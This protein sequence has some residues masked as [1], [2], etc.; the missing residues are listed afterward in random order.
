MPSAGG[1]PGC[2]TTEERTRIL[3][4][5]E[6][7]VLP[8]FCAMVLI[9]EPDVKCRFVGC[10]DE[11]QLEQSGDSGCDFAAYSIETAHPVLERTKLLA[12]S[13]PY[14]EAYPNNC[15]RKS[16]ESSHSEN[17]LASATCCCGNCSRRSSR[18]PPKQHLVQHSGVSTVL[19]RGGRKPMPASTV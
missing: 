9:S 12:H 15:D 6:A 17:R 19:Q 11:R 13:M 3:L 4:S 7:C 10:H 14:Q 1:S 2:K 8:P 18:Q 16:V 5:L